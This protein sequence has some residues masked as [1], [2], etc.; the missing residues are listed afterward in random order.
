MEEGGLEWNLSESPL[1]DVGSWTGQFCSG[2]LNPL[3]GL[4]LHRALLFRAGTGDFLGM[5]LDRV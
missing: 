2:F 1:S 3:S 5:D 4:L